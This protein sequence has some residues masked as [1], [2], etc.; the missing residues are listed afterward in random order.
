MYSVIKLKYHFCFV[1][2][3]DAPICQSQLVDQLIGVTAEESISI[4]CRVSTIFPFLDYYYCMFFDYYCITDY[5]WSTNTVLQLEAITATIHVIVLSC[6][7]AC[8]PQIEAVLE[9][10][11]KELNHLVAIL[12][13]Y[14]G[15]LI[16]MK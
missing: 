7:R 11:S 15:S 16:F 12:Q 10:V 6:C 8:C 4:N 14:A 2:F 3:S 13:H 5:Y 9:L 1:S